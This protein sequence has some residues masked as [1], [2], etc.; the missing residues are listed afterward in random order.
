[1]QFDT[2]RPPVGQLLYDLKYGGKTSEPK[3]QIA[4]DLA[5]TAAH[6]VLHTWR[7]AIDAI[8][9]V[10]PSNARAVQPVAVVA[11]ALAGRLGVPVC[12]KCVAKVKQTPQLKDL[13]DYDKRKEALKDA[14]TVVP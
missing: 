11:D 2:T 9:P 7:L 13:K 3:Q 12:A 10:P 5:E 8:V 14:F 1:M 6:F 4:N